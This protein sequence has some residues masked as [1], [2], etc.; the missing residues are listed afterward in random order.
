MGAR[1]TSLPFSPSSGP[2][3]SPSC[4][5]HSPGSIQHVRL[6]ELRGTRWR[7]IADRVVAPPDPGSIECYAVLDRAL[8]AGRDR[9]RQLEENATETLQEEE[10]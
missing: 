9:A 7:K 10:R 1:D 4:S 3:S 8:D 2:A 6:R 5:P